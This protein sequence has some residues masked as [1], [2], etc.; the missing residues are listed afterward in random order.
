MIKTA[1]ELPQEC[2]YC[3]EKQTT[4]SIDNHE[5]S[6]PVKP[7]ECKFKWAGCTWKAKTADY[8]SHL[9][10]CEFRK[11]TA[12]EL[13]ERCKGEIKKGQ[14]ASLEKKN[15]LQMLSSNDIAYKEKVYCTFDQTKIE[16]L[17]TVTYYLALI[18]LSVVIIQKLLSKYE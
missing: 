5:N 7:A 10:D 1:Q 14:I 13:L 8:E 17:N 3:R 11:K 9:V 4:Q 12:S 6:C 16:S 15:I 18:R 2:Q